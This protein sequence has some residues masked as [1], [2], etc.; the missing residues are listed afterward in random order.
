MYT[1][2]YNIF[3]QLKLYAVQEEVLHVVEN[4]EFIGFTLPSTSV[5]STFIPIGSDV[6]FANLYSLTL[7]VLYVVSLLLFIVWYHYNPSTAKKIDEMIERNMD[8]IV[9]VRIT[10]TAGLAVEVTARLVSC[11]VWTIYVENPLGLFLAV[12]LPQIYL[13]LMAVCQNVFVNVYIRCIK[14]QSAGIGSP[15]HSIATLYATA[16]LLFHVFCPAIILMFAYPT[17]I[18]VIFSFI[19]SYLFATTIFYAILVKIYSNENTSIKKF[20]K[21]TKKEKLCFLF[22]V[23]P[24]WLVILYLHCLVLLVSYSLL[25]GKGSVITTGPLFLISLIP[26][27]LLSIIA[28]I[29]KKA[30]LNEEADADPESAEASKKSTATQQKSTKKNRA[31][32]SQNKIELGSVKKLTYIP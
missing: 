5:T 1:M 2:S 15:L 18:I 29:A 6:V 8:L 28:W 30:T 13:A 26:S 32:A 19:M 7:C 17:Q 25:I 21:D 22:I 23:G 27:V 14:G 11:I 3:S 12:W 9:G 31:K 20:I 4:V 10:S 16:F 24:L